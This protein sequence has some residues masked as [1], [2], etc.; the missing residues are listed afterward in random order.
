MFD[1]FLDN[2]RM[3]VASCCKFGWMGMVDSVEDAASSTFPAY[4]SA[5]LLAIVRCRAQVE[6]ALGNKV[7][8]IEGMT[9]QFLALA[10]AAD[11][12]AIGICDEV[13]ARKTHLKVKQ[14]DRMANEL[15][16]LMNTL[17]TYLSD[18]GLALLDGT[19]RTLCSRA[20]RGGGV[21]GDGP[22]GLAAI[23]DLERLGRVYVLCLGD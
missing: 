11:A 3:N 1:E 6:K 23:E 21:Q 18:E 5:S 2:V 8:R 14:A 20:G 19:R 4:L 16:F 15:Q 10:T 22:E 12:V 13:K 7:R 9:Y 17:K